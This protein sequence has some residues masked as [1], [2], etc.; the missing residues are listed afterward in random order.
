MDELLETITTAETMHDTFRVWITTEPHNQFSITLLQV[1][2]YK[3]FMYREV[4]ECIS[5]YI[6]L[7]LDRPHLDRLHKTVV[8]LFTIHVWA[9]N[10][11]LF[12]SL[13]L[14]LNQVYKRS[15]PGNTCWLEKNI[16]R[17]FTEPVRSQQ[18]SHVE[19][20][21]VQRGLSPH[22]CAGTELNFSGHGCIDLAL[23]HLVIF[24]FFFPYV[25]IW[26]INCLRNDANLDLWV[27]TYLMSSTLLISLQV[28]NLLK[29]TWMIVAPKRWGTG[30]CKIVRSS[31]HLPSLIGLCFC[32]MCHG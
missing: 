3:A 32:R 6:P 29:D 17:H 19:A 26:C 24:W 12:I 9:Q 2:F 15:T 22:C 18:P 11:C 8:H 10:K 16:C 14:V 31:Y 1:S 20:F 23:L 28:W 30:K 21:A 5:L 13:P 7:H 25:I 4:L 27:G